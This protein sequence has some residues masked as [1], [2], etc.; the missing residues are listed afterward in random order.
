[1]AYVMAVLYHLEGDEP[2]AAQEALIEGLPQNALYVTNPLV[3]P[4]W[5]TTDGEG[6]NCGFDLDAFY[7]TPDG[8]RKE[9][10]SIVEI[11]MMMPSYSHAYIGELLGLTEQEVYA[12]LETEQ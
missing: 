12:V 2:V 1:M 6:P 5:D 11:H 4:S 9:V 7:Y 3:M 8:V 10:A